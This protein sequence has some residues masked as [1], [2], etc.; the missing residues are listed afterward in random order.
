MFDSIGMCSTAACA[1]TGHK[2]GRRRIERT[3]FFTRTR[4][5]EK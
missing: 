5:E 2:R 1:M 3:M 4:S